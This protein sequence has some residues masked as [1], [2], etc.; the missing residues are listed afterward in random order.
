MKITAD[1]TCEGKILREYLKKIG[2][3][4]AL[5]T[6]LKQKENGIVQNGARVSVRAVLHAG[7]VLEL[8]V[9]DEENPANIVPTAYPLDILSETA[10]Y[11]VVNKPAGMPTHPSHGHFDDTLANA[12][13]FLFA[14]RDEVFRPRFISRLDKD[15]SGVIL[16]AKNPLAASFLSRQM[17]RREIKKSY[18]ALVHG[19]IER[20]Q[21]IESGIRRVR[22]SVI[23]RET[24]PVG[25]GDYAKTEVFPLWNDGEKSLVRLCPATGRTHQLRVHLAGTGHPLFG[26]GLYGYED[27]F[28]RHALHA[29][30]LEFSDRAGARIRVCA[31]LP[32]DFLRELEVWGKEARRVADRAIENEP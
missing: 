27:G 12:L 5:L 4:A 8:A 14:G 21:T 2:I 25:E 17:A 11:L 32:E 24:V 23:L 26:D 7:D 29:A 19:K 22:E 6:R 1:A 20:P 15:T 10:D 18:L 9:E 16:A 31:P 30:A 3:S 28:P 13:A